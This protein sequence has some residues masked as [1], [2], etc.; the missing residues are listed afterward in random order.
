MRDGWYRDFRNEQGQ[1]YP[2]DN[3]AQVQSLQLNTEGHKKENNWNGYY[4]KNAKGK[5]LEGIFKDGA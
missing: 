3:S 2:F 1:K 5:I 4:Y